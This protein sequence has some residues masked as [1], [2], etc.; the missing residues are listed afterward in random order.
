[1][2]RSISA[3]AISGFVR[4]V[5]YSAGTPARSN[6]PTQINDLASRDSVGLDTGTPLDDRDYQVPFAF[7]GRLNRITVDIGETSA[8]PEALRDMQAR[9]QQRD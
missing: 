5:R 3:R 7:I 2:A 9:M 4:A 6:D 1:M 8:T